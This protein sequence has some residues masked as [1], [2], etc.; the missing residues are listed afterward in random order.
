MILRH[1]FRYIKR[2]ETI[3]IYIMYIEILKINGSFLCI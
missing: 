1:I 2:I 3:N